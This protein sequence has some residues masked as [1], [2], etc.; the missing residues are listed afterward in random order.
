MGTQ[1]HGWEQNEQAMSHITMRRLA[2]SAATRDEV[3]GFARLNPSYGMILAG[4][5]A[6]NFSKEG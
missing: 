3:M 6:K 5:K 1:L 4:G 2:I